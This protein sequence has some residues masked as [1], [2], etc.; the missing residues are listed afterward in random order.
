MA[1][2]EISYNGDGGKFNQFLAAVMREYLT[3][4]PS[5][6]DADDASDSEV[7]DK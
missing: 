1:S 7:N 3:F 4:D 5:S 2:V 6:P